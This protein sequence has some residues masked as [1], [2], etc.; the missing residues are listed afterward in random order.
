MR[1]ITSRDGQMGW[2]EPDGTFTPYIPEKDRPV[3]PDFCYMCKTRRGRKAKVWPPCEMCG[4]TVCLR[5][6][7]TRNHPRHCA[8]CSREY[9]DARMEIVNQKHEA[10]EQKRKEDHE[11]YLQQPA[12]CVKCEVAC[13]VKDLARHLTMIPGNYRGMCGPCLHKEQAEA[14]VARRKMAKPGLVEVC[15]GRHPKPIEDGG[16]GY[17]F[18]HAGL[19]LGLG[20]IVDLPGGQVGTVVSTY[21]DYA[22]PVISIKGLVE[23]AQ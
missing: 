18:H 13:T 4:K 20:D 3:D 2:L 19:K 23:R 8:K 17:A 12:V 7:T 22:K 9:W 14:Q 21:S 15:Y 11:N 5:C 10:A 6:V 1:K 16:S